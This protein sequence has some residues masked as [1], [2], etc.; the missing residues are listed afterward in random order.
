MTSRPSQTM[1]EGPDGRRRLQ[2]D[3]PW[4][5]RMGYSRAVQ[6]GPMI[7]VAGCVGINADGT[8]PEG[9]TAQTRR[10]VERI[11]EALEPFG[12]SLHHV[13]KVRIYTTAIDRWEEI[14]AVMGPAFDDIRPANVLVEVAKLVEGALVEIEAEAFLPPD[15]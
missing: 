7:W 2:T 10:C 3:S 5:P 12:G 13:V 4:E 14:A 15:A 1:I 6:A 9:L 8:W 11:R